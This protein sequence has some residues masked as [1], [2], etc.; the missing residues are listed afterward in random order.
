MQNGMVWYQASDSAGAAPLHRTNKASTVGIDQHNGGH[1][2]QHPVSSGQM[3]GTWQN[4]DDFAQDS[5]MLLFKVNSSSPFQH[6]MYVNKKGNSNPGRHQ[7]PVQCINVNPSQ[8]DNHIQ[9]KQSFL[10]GALQ[11]KP[12]LIDGNSQIQNSAFLEQYASHSNHNAAYLP[13]QYDPNSAQYSANLN[14]RIDNPT[15]FSSPL[16]RNDCYSSNDN[17]SSINTSQPFSMASG[18]HASNRPVS[19]SHAFSQKHNLLRNMNKMVNGHLHSNGQISHNVPIS[20]VESEMSQSYRSDQSSSSFMDANHSRKLLPAQDASSYNLNGINNHQTAQSRVF[21]QDSPSVLPEY[22]RHHLANNIPFM[23][24]GA[25]VGN[26]NEDALRRCLGNSTSGLSY[27]EEQQGYF[28]K[29]TNISNLK[30][31]SVSTLS[32]TSQMTQNSSPACRNISS[33]QPVSQMLQNPA[34]HQSISSIHQ[35]SQKAQISSAALQNISSLQPIQQMVQSPSVANQSNFTH[36]NLQM[37]QNSTAAYRSISSTVQTTQKAQSPSAALQNI[38]SMQLI[39]QMFQSPSVANQSNFTQPNLQMSQNSTAAYRSISST[40]QATQKAQIPSAALQNVSSMQPI[41]QML[42]SSSAANQNISIQ[43]NP[44]MSQN[45]T[46]AYPTI[47]STV[48][49]TRMPQNSV[50]TD[51]DISFAMQVSKMPPSLSSAFQSKPAFIKQSIIEQQTSYSHQ[52]ALLNSNKTVSSG[53]S[54]QNSSTTFDEILSY[55]SNDI[56]QMNLINQNKN[57][58]TENDSTVNSLRPS[59]GVSVSVAKGQVS[60]ET[61]QHLNAPQQTITETPLKS[62]PPYP[63]AQEH[64]FLVTVKKDAQGEGFSAQNVILIGKSSPFSEVNNVL[65]SPAKQ[66]AVEKTIQDTSNSAAPLT[67]SQDSALMTRT[68][69]IGKSTASL[70]QQTELP[71]QLKRAVPESSQSIHLVPSPSHS[72]KSVA[73]SNNG[74]SVEIVEDNLKKCNMEATHGPKKLHYS[75]HVVLREELRR[76]VIKHLRGIISNIPAT[77]QKLPVLQNEG[78]QSQETVESDNLSRKTTSSGQSLSAD[79]KTSNR[80]LLAKLLG[81]GLSRANEPQVAIVPPITQKPAEAENEVFSNVNDEVP[82]KIVNVCS[83]VEMPSDLKESLEL[84]KF[85]NSETNEV[86]ALGQH[87]NSECIIIDETVEVITPSAEQDS[88]VIFVRCTNR[89]DDIEKDILIADVSETPTALNCGAIKSPIDKEIT[90]FTSTELESE[91]VPV[92]CPKEQDDNQCKETQI[93][94]DVSLEKNITMVANDD[95]TLCVSSSVSNQTTHENCKE[96]TTL[97]EDEIKTADFDLSSVPCVTWTLPELMVLMDSLSVLEEDMESMSCVDRLIN[98]FWNGDMEDFT[99]EFQKANTM[100]KVFWSFWNVESSTEIQTIRGVLSEVKPDEFSKVAK[101]CKVLGDEIMAA[102]DIHFKSSWLNLNEQVDDID[103]EFGYPPCLSS[104]IYNCVTKM[105]ES[106]PSINQSDGGSHTQ[107]VAIESSPLVT[108]KDEGSPAIPE[109]TG[110]IHDDPLSKVQVKVLNHEDAKKLLEE[111]CSKEQQKVESVTENSKAPSETTI[112]TVCCGPC[113]VRGIHNNATNFTCSS[114][115]SK[116]STQR[117]MGHYINTELVMEDESSRIVIESIPVASPSEN[118]SQSELENI[119]KPD[120]NSVG[121]GDEKAQEPQLLPSASLV[122]S[123]IKSDEKIKHVDTKKS[124]KQIAGSKYEMS[125]SKEQ[126]HLQKRSRLSDVDYP[127]EG[128]RASKKIR[129]G[130][131]LKQENPKTEYTRDAKYKQ[132]PSLKKE[133]WLDPKKNGDGPLNTGT[134]QCKLSQEH[135]TSKGVPSKSPTSKQKSDSSR[136]IKNLSVKLVLYGSDSPGKHVCGLSSRQSSSEH[137]QSPKF[138]YHRPSRIRTL[139]PKEINLTL[140]ERNDDALGSDKNQHGAEVHEVRK[141]GSGQNEA[142]HH[143]K[144]S[145]QNSVKSRT[146]DLKKPVQN[147]AS[148]YHPV[149]LTNANHPRN[150]CNQN[151]G[152]E[153][154]ANHFSSSSSHHKLATTN[155][156]LK[157]E[158]FSKHFNEKS[159]SKRESKHK[160]LEPS[161]QKSNDTVAVKNDN[162]SSIHVKRNK[163]ELLLPIKKRKL[164]HP[165]IKFKLGSKLDS[166]KTANGRQKI[167]KLASSQEEVNPLQ[168]KLCPNLFSKDLNFKK[169]KTEVVEVTKKKK[170]SVSQKS[171]VPQCSV[172]SNWKNKVQTSSIKR[173]SSSKPEEKSQ[174]NVE[175]KSTDTFQ[176]FKKKY[177]LK[178]GK[179]K[180]LK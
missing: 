50:A 127:D 118:I 25:S 123:T 35:N 160:S 115:C 156:N 11:K 147:N 146:E 85:L 90:N 64:A 137:D 93:C 124:G 151:S 96:T 107:L 4:K 74:A 43:P 84:Q 28:A 110:D 70:V 154:K 162:K 114:Q 78:N 95:D 20:A 14:S 71:K 17:S 94:Q 57:K 31:Q 150:F 6:L 22:L 133:L 15:V 138:K 16:E 132:D 121:N 139:P 104:Q 155:P 56:N 39:P 37:S 81:P 135:D 165:E 163:G 66:A 157:Q 72:A 117:E 130:D 89:N 177:L 47:S 38:S 63:K 13:P 83:L 26:H 67:R 142:T 92:I 170:A 116:T 82:F 79:G 98:D 158:N 91:S 136:G 33:M 161:G 103:K 34:T 46:T 32:K 88:D 106:S 129:K 159:K 65:L 180:S 120:I 153:E 62:P 54:S 58:V 27:E 111:I 59:K 8:S 144:N 168:F 174:R 87:S 75:D 76:E 40:V 19:V 175:S 141:K 178:E 5:S 80:G 36:P 9:S 68:Q 102:E 97:S 18:T 108:E 29:P 176:E 119:L 73:E 169:E 49:T 164:I 105:S 60:S 128:K 172:Q 143:L 23:L 125:P 131:N 109:K 55:L 52:K 149:S 100:I 122:V 30:R 2:S 126:P 171:P 42:Q 99:A 148:E 167:P 69:H 7:L 140:K 145:I 179:L 21:S 1:V 77:T 86:E 166:I 45:S 41:L 113:W 48:Q 101:H 152:Q 53:E 112:E 3:S 134:L 24:S 173:P 44:K 61:S 10:K 51:Q 12:V